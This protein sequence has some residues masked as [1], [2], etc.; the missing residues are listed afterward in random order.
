MEGGAGW[1]HVDV[2]VAACVQLEVCGARRFLLAGAWP[3]AGPL[4][5]SCRA[6]VGG[7]LAETIG[8]CRGNVSFTSGRLR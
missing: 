1:Q 6:T 8:V 4:L 3:V 7:L 2:L 5:P